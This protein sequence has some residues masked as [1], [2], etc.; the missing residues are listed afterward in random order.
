M[1]AKPHVHGEVGLDEVGLQQADLKD[2]HVH[3]NLNPAELYEHAIEMA[4][5]N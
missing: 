1:Y 4:K 3:W 5:Q 2:V